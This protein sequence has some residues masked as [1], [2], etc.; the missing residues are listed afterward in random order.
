VERN[1]AIQKLDSARGTIARMREQSKATVQRAQRLM[2]MAAGGALSGFLGVR[3]PFVPGTTVDSG[4]AVGAGLALV[5]LSG[6]IRDEA[7]NE[8]VLGVSGGILAAE[9]CDATRN[10]LL[11]PP[12]PRIPQ[13]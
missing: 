2:G 8:F 10:M 3:M 6:W 13:G 5:A 1:E 7:T 12:A 4:K 11:A 9:A